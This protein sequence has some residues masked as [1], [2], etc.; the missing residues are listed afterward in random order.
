MNINSTD[1]ITNEELWRITHQKSKEIQIKR[2]KWNWTGHTLRKETGAIEKTALYWNPQ[3]Y[4]RRGRPKRTWRRAIEDE[5]STRRSWNEVKW[6]AGDRNVWKL[7]M[8]A[9]CSI[10]SE[11]IWWWWWWWI[12]INMTRTDNNLN[13]GNILR[14]D[15]TADFT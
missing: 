2:R 10:R 15:C 3:E 5:I 9:V 4:R 7:S 1:K 13:R 6:S 8:D 14:S 11:R 12:Y